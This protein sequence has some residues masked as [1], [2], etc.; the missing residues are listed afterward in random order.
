MKPKMILFDL[1]GTLLPMDQT[2]FMKDYFGR[3]ARRLTPRGYDPKDL[4]DSIWAGT[5][6][7]VRN[8]GSNRNETAFW[9]KMTE[10]WGERIQE[11]MPRFDAFYR[12]EFDEVKA[13]C[14][15][16][17]K[18]ADTVRAL[19]DMGY[20]V[21][22]AT[23]PLFPTIATEARIRWTGLSPE[24]FEL[25]TTY[26]NIGY[27]KPNPDYYRELCVRLN[28]SPEDSL[29][30][31]NDVSEDMIAETL[32]MKVFLLTD[33]LLNKGEKDITVYPRGSFDDLLTYINDL[34]TT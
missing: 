30:V 28:V 17:P 3:L 4:I 26:E 34:E 25:V 27:C 10:I 15:Y 8:D 29:M 23:N 21:A 18:A 19:K 6:M 14:G 22:L 31:G 1:D 11:D 33:C 2:V 9:E 13:S 16:D 12:E 5:A 7:M 32:G 20:R 24:D